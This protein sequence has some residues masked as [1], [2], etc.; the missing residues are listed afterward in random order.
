MQRTYECESFR[1]DEKGRLFGKIL[2]RFMLESIGDLSPKDSS[3][4]QYHLSTNLV[5]FTREGKD[6]FILGHY[7]IRGTFY[8]ME[9]TLESVRFRN[10]RDSQYKNK[11]FTRVRLTIDESS[12]YLLEPILRDFH[13]KEI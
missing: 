7:K 12:N 9:F 5:E 1:P 2:N 11:L 3:A 8:G 10:S 6:C 13:F 4:R